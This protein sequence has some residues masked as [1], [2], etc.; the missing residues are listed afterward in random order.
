MEKLISSIIAVLPIV[1]NSPLS[2][3]NFSYG[4]SYSQML[5]RLLLSFCSVAETQTVISS[6]KGSK[7]SSGIGYSASFK[8]TT[9]EKGYKY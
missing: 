4:L 2:Q 6:I 1:Q 8:L 7:N 9:G 5:K 3:E